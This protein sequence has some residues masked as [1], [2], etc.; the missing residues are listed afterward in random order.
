MLQLKRKLPKVN[1]ELAAHIL[2]NEEAENETNEAGD[3]D[4]KKKS[5]KKK[6]LGSEVLK[7]DDRFNILFK[8]KVLYSS[9][10]AA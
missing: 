8:N 2:E 4:A 6:A 3:T 9:Q 7:E 1:R 10:L 5:K